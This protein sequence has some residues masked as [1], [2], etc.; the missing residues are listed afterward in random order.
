MMQKLIE[1]VTKKKLFECNI[2]QYQM[3]MEKP[4][5]IKL[6]SLFFFFWSFSLLCSSHFYHALLPVLFTN[7][8]PFHLLL[9]GESNLIA[10]MYILYLIPSFLFFFLNFLSLYFLFFSQSSYLPFLQ[11][12]FFIPSSCLIFTH[13]DTYTRT[14]TYTQIHNTDTYT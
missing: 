10:F 11:H 5:L 12:T 13:I 1:I 6:Q 4:V 2:N 7:F 14:D 9:L 3:R 8:F